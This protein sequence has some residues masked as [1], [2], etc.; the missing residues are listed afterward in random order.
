MKN[1]K[2]R[3]D[4]SSDDITRLLKESS[5]PSRIDIISL[6]KD[7]CVN[8]SELHKRLKANGV[9]IPVSTVY[10]AVNNLSAAGILDKK[11]GEV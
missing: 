7:D 5:L 9:K 4:P 1:E 10:R 6:L 3:S 11:D 2:R 8:L